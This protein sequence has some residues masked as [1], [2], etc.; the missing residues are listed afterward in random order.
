MSDRPNAAGAKFRT[1]LVSE[2]G[3]AVLMLLFMLV[4]AL[5]PALDAADGVL[6]GTRG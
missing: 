6:H 3:I 1:Y 4:L 2:R 5:V